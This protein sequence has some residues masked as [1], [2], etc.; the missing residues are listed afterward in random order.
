MG[1]MYGRQQGVQAVSAFL[2]QHA[3]DGVRISALPR[4]AGMSERAL[5]N[6]FHREHGLSPKQFD[7]HE[8]LQRARDA[9]SHPTPSSTVTTIAAQHGFFELGRFA[10][11]YKRVYGESPSQTIRECRALPARDARRG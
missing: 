8:R 4:I 1:H 10:A 2:H 3:A 9:L 11:R 5:R 7:L 6:A